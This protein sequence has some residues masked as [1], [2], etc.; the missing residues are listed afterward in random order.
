M[1]K[2]P[3]VYTSTSKF[4]AWVAITHRLNNENAEGYV[5][6]D[7]VHSSPRVTCSFCSCHDFGSSLW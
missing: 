6:D 2:T 7:P 4:M 1:W 5:I 3:V